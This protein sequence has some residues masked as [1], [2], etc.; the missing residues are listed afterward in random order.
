MPGPR[1][2]RVFRDLAKSPNWYVEWRDLEGKKHCESC[3]P[4]EANAQERAKEIRQELQ[5][6]RKSQ[7]LQNERCD[8]IDCTLQI[9]IPLNPTPL[10]INLNV[11][12]TEEEVRL[13]TEQVRHILERG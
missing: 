1:K 11:R 12:M 7:R 10:P 9:V 5:R 2:V 8:G 4:E 3:G 13:A 6:Q